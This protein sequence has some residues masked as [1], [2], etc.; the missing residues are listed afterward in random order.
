MNEQAYLEHHGI[1]GMKWGVRRYQNYDGSYTRKGLQH[2]KESE[3]KY[4]DANEKY[5]NAKRAYKDAKKRTSD[6]NKVFAMKGAV[7]E[8]KNN[9]KIA[10]YRM[11]K[12]Y[13]QLKRDKK[14]DKGKLLYQTGKTITGS[15]SA[16][17]R[18]ATIA[19]GAGTVAAILASNGQ[20]KPAMYVGAAGLGLEFING[21]V[22]VKNE[23]E[24]KNLRAYYS[25]NR[26]YRNW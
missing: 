17:S 15:R 22:G 24:A 7:K 6:S 10:K 3:K 9:R 23:Y 13:D 4:D 19:T 11:S 8:A 5:K 18:A 21:I 20:T 2:Y 26:R 12:D 25:H 1:K 14:A 16:L